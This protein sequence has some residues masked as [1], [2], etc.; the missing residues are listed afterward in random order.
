MEELIGLWC[1]LYGKKV[2]GVIRYV[3]NLG[4]WWI[5][6]EFWNIISLSGIVIKIFGYVCKVMRIKEMIYY[7]KFL[8]VK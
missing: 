1:F 5:E 2:Y 6:S 4:V 8:I 7:K 3:I